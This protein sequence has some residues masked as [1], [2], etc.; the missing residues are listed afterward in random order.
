MMSDRNF[1]LSETIVPRQVHLALL[2]W[3]ALMAGFALF[4][5]RYPWS[6]TVY[7][8]YS[9]ASRSWWMQGDIYRTV[10]D[11]Y[12]RYS[13]LFAVAL[14]PFSILSDSWGNAL[15]R[16]VNCCVY[17]AGLWAWGRSF[18]SAPWTPNRAAALF[19]LVLP[20]SLHSMYNAQANLL[21]LGGVLLGMAAAS[22]DSWNQA[23]GWLA[24][25]T[26]IKGYPLALALVLSAL[27]P[28]RFAPRFAG[29]L[30][31][32]LLLPFVAGPPHY[33]SSEYASWFNHLRDSASIMRER[34]RSVDHL[35]SV[36]GHPLDPRVF[37]LAQL[38][39]GM[40]ILVACL[41]FR[42]RADLRQQLL[43]AF[44]LFSA[45]VVL[46]GPATESCTYVVIA[47]AIGWA[48]VESFGRPSRWSMRMLLV[49]SLCLMGPAVTDM[50]G[51]TLRNFFGEHGSQPIGGILFLVFLL[52]QM[53][54]R[55]GAW[56]PLG[57][58][59]PNTVFRAAA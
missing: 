50:V 33:V 22:R 27:Y 56:T 20:T 36:F 6:H 53:V 13:P 52:L 45:W 1:T 9:T 11:A 54:T 57:I 40:G 31:V 42:R 41:V 8:V 14:T 15:W 7:N 34:L 25:A 19:L 49:V 59:Q 47:P 32:G 29:A 18:L 26:L 35:L 39:V 2:I 43:Q 28:R 30:C 17:A 58:N 5:F 46:F 51:S 10:D 44:L 23:A 3:C 24:V 55:S 21:M 12:Y 16:I 48:L 38:I 4:G 37:L